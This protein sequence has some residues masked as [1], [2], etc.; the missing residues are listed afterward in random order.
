MCIRQD[1]PEGVT[2][3]VS[4]SSILKCALMTVACVVAL[5]GCAGSATGLSGATSIMQPLQL[6]GLVNAIP[7]LKQIHSDVSNVNIDN[8]IDAI[9]V[10]CG[11]GMIPADQCVRALTAAKMYKELTKARMVP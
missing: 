8:I 3:S 1:H 4:V 11:A 5:T 6:L 9:N 2:S 10:G 7:T